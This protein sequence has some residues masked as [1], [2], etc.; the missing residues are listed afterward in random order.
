MSAP[1]FPES[2]LARRF[3][4]VLSAAPCVTSSLVFNEEAAQGSS[5]P[6]KGRE[7]AS[8]SWLRKLCPYKPKEEKPDQAG[9][10]A[11]CDSAACAVDSSGAAPRVLH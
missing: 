8:S 1:F 11:P 3:A 9:V 10:A 7:G 6:M 2:S 5:C 4:G